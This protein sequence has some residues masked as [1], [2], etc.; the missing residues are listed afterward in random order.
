MLSKNKEQTHEMPMG[1]S[2]AQ[3]EMGAQAIERTVGLKVVQ[4][5]KQPNFKTI[6][7]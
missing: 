3:A 1:V 4:Y 6:E 5:E 2:A 7:Q